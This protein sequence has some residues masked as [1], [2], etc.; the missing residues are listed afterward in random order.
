M[1]P[2]KCAQCGDSPGLLMSVVDKSAGVK[3]NLTK[4]FGK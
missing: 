2:L 4:D 1:E 3:I